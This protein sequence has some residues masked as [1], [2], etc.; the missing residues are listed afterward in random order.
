M[1]HRLGLRER[2]AGQ[3]MIFWLALAIT[4]TTHAAATDGLGTDDRG[5]DA[6]VMPGMV[7]VQFKA[8]I[9][10]PH[11]AAKS[12]VA[13]FDQVAAKHQV[14]AIEKAFPF[15]E[16]V[17]AKRALSEKAE[18]LRRIYVVRYRTPMR[19]RH[20]AAML[21]QDPNVVFAEP[22]F[23]RRITEDV[24]ASMEALLPT[25][26][27]DALFGNMTH[28]A[29]LRL[30]EAWDVVKGEQGSVVIAI[31][32]GGTE[33]R[34]PDL[35]ANVW[36]NPGEVD[37]NGIDDDGNGYVD[38]IHG[39]NFAADPDT[40]DPTGLANSPSNARHGTGVAGAAVA[41]TNNAVGVAGTSWN[42]RFMA[43]N[44]GCPNQDGL[45]CFGFAGILYAAMNGADIINA[46]WGGEGRSQAE[47]QVIEMALEAGALVVAAAGNE[48][49]GPSYPASFGESVI[50]VAATDRHDEHAYFSNI[51]ET[52]D[53]S[54]PGV[55]IY[56]TVSSGYQVMTG[57][58]MAAPHVSGALAIARSLRPA[59]DLEKRLK[60]HSER[61]DWDGSDAYEDVFGAGL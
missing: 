22:Q 53:I 26:P 52:N 35:M 49:R 28:L 1:R 29:H 5:A 10:I 3:W 50:A 48:G 51:Y 8:G 58:S 57:T 17:A 13:S 6:A 41:V 40:N 38:D 36:T 2:T 31:V 27:N 30:P 7:V 39:W 44:A 33:W 43:V 60:E 4:T 23:I 45:I 59:D 61:L 32:D 47:I 14:Y 46:S 21:A 56:S 9:E 24:S 20:V 12:G 34:H 42:A 25:E 11:G 54:A 37:G 55:G 16:A 18:A 19:P 15:L